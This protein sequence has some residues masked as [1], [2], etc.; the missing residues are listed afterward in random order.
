LLLLL[1]NG[2]DKGLF[3][4]LDKAKD[5]EKLKDLKAN[6]KASALSGLRRHILT[7]KANYFLMLRRLLICKI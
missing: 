4:F 5:V 7:I 1:D 2:N 6:L 3:I